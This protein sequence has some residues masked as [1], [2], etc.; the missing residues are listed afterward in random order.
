M[1]HQRRGSGYIYALRGASHCVSRSRWTPNPRGY[2]LLCRLRDPAVLRFSHRENYRAWGHARGSDCAHES[3]TGWLR[4]GRNQDHNSAAQTNPGRPGFHRWKVRHALSRPPRPGGSQ[5][6]RRLRLFP[7]LYAI[8]DAS[9]AKPI[10]SLLSFAENLARGGTQLIQVRAKGVSSLQLYEISRAIVGRVG[11]SARIIVNDRPDIA[12]MTGAAGVHVGQEDLPV[13]VARTICAR[14]LWVGVSTHSLDQLRAADATS[15]DYIAVGPI[16]PTATKQK[17]DP[18][19]GLDF[20]RSARNFTRKPLVAIGGIT[21]KS[22]QE[23]FR[24]GADSVAVISDL[25]NA[26]DPALRASEYLEIAR[27]A[28]GA[29]R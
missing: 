18:V 29:A 9:P 12:A 3:R 25:G 20:L 2:G 22:A 13:E 6:A 11:D 23:V 27:V 4:G 28:L 5:V 14:P 7:A 16:F 21:V 15:A 24:A 17:P 19:V 26:P 1:P 8:L 10:E